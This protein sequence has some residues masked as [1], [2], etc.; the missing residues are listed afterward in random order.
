MLLE[1]MVVQKHER[2]VRDDV[3]DEEL[4]REHDRLIVYV[5]PIRILSQEVDPQSISH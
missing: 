1:V 4:E 5:H 3:V 2:G